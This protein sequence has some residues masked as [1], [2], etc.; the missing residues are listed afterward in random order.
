M[1]LSI[2]KQLK[3]ETTSKHKTVENIEHYDEELYEELRRLRK[4]IA[5]KLG[6]PLLLYSLT[7]VL[8]I[9]QPSIPQQKRLSLT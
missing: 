1:K 6:N 9:W 5:Q 7:E 2:R 8:L 4:E 3:Q